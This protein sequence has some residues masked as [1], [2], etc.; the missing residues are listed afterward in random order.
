M[1]WLLEAIDAIPLERLRP[2]LNELS[3]GRRERV[4]RA[5]YESGKVQM[6]LAELLLRYALLRETGRKE[7]PGISSGEKG[8]PFFPEHPDLQFNLSHCKIAVACALDASPVGVDVQSYQPLLRKDQA[9]PAIFRVL[10]ETERSWVE[11]GR[12][13]AD[14]DRRF[15]AV[16]TCKEAYGK[17]NGNGI[18]YPLHET[19]FLPAETPW[20]QYGWSFQCQLLPRAALTVCAAAPMELRPVRLPELLGSE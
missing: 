5:R 13:A 11:Q 17:A 15:A 14:C 18:L 9:A 6:I 20:E 3:E 12:D 4:L 1:L 19:A 2:A 10:S 8:K 7:L 16:W